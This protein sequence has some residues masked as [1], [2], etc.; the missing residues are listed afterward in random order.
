MSIPFLRAGSPAEC[1]ATRKEIIVGNPDFRHVST[2]HVERRNLTM[3]MSIRHFTR[4]TNAQSKKVENHEAA[5][6]LHYVDYNSPGVHQS[7]RV[8]PAMEAGGCGS[9]LDHFRIVG[10][11]EK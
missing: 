5:I 2:S 3:R 9:R 10:L 7:L 6:A 11:L 4:L 8:T 1:N